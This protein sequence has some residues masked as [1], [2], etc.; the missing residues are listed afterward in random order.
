MIG[1]TVSDVEA[2]KNAG[3]TTIG[4][5]YGFHGKK[6]AKSKPDYLVDHIKD[7][8]RIILPGG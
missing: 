3:V 4:V 2:G 6:L 1:D 7:I 5:T 8:L